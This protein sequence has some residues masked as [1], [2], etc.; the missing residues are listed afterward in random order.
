MISFYFLKNTAVGNYADDSSLYAYD[1]KLESRICNLKQK[2]SILSNWLYDN[3][4]VLYPIKCQFTLFGVKENDQ[5]CQ[6]RAQGI[7]F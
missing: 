4:M 5:H 6:E 1:K 2:F 3:Y 7:G